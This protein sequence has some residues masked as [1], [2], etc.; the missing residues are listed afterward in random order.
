MSEHFSRRDML[1]W[2]SAGAGAAAVSGGFLLVGRGADSGGQVAAP[3][4]KR[5]SSKVSADSDSEPQTTDPSTP[6][7]AP[8][9]AGE[10][11][12]APA[13]DQSSRVLVVLELNGGNDG[14]SMFVPHGMGSY[15]DM[16]KATALA[17]EDVLDLDGELG[18]HPRLAKLH[19]RGLAVV[20]GVGSYQPDGSHFAMSDRWWSGDA[21]GSGGYDT[22]MWGRLADVIGDGSAPAVAVS[23]GAGTHPAL[24]SRKAGT[25]SLPN[26]D[27]AGY[28]AGAGEDDPLRRAFQR[29]ITSYGAGPLENALGRAR[30]SQNLASSFAGRLVDLGSSDADG[31]GEP[32]NG[33]AY[34]GSELGN[35]LNFA[36]RL[37]TSGQGVRIIHLTMGGYDTHENH[38]DS[39]AALMDELDAA[40]DA[41]MRDLESR[42]VADRVLTM[43]TSEFGRRAADNGSS[44]LD[45]GTA[46][47]VALMGPINHGRFGQHPS[48]TDLEDDNLKATVGFDQYYATVAEGWFGVP[49]TEL[50]T[51]PVETISGIF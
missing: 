33:V 14:L 24:L 15:Y 38:P 8:P 21:N 28:L 35:S 3:S 32:D 25:L 30:Y 48:L 44:G 40:L 2:M 41:F 7:S 39:Y 45:H 5:P 50:F 22:G 29:A 4:N 11:P 17:Q 49:S 26:P 36:S 37:I 31:D 51:S 6:E 16:R 1:K 20:E 43:T 18:L 47:S 23:I 10:P 19:Q 34:P 12:T 42:G 27:A 9:D 13:P 46:S